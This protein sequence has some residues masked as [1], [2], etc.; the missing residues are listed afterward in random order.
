[1]ARVI[2]I[3]KRQVY[4]A[5]F[6]AAAVARMQ[7]CDSVVGLAKELGVCWSMLYQWK[8]KQAKA[9]RAQQEHAEASREKALQEEIAALKSAL[10]DKVLEV[11][12]FRGALQRVAAQAQRQPPRGGVASTTRSGK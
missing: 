9:A 8:D 1:V 7:S 3:K 5:E 12:F 6:K 10:A 2:K 11:D 4:S